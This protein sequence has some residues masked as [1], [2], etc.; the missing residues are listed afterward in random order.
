[1]DHQFCDLPGGIKMEETEA[2]N[3][4]NEV[5]LR[6]VE[7]PLLMVKT[8]AA[9]R[10][11]KWGAQ[12]QVK[13]E[14]EDELAQHW[15]AQWQFL[16]A[17]Q[18]QPRGWGN[19]PLQWSENALVS[20]EREADTN[21][22]GE[23][24]VQISSGLHGEAPEVRKSL[25]PQDDISYTMSREPLWNEEDIS[26]EIRRKRFRHFCYRETEGP[27]EVCSHLRQLCHHWLKPE[28]LTK[29]QILELLILEQFLTVL[30]QEMQSWVKEGGPETCA[31]A[32]A[33][34][35]NFLLSQEELKGW[36]EEVRPLRI[37][38]GQFQVS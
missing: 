38:D 29:E 4:T 26:A 13:Q 20:L 32:V 3:Q 25:R 2:P 23:E 16:N 30:P 31:Q 33:L 19:L 17:L 6:E 36:E 18:T 1:M 10:F 22:R 15:E 28:Q 11:S 5:E 14:P 8:G 34:A 37:W 24:V 7:K 27:R 9:K 12:L 35:E 21:P